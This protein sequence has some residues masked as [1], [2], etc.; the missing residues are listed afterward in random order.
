MFSFEVPVLGLQL[1]LF[2]I[3]FLR[4]SKGSKQHGTYTNKIFSNYEDSFIPV[5]LGIKA[6]GAS[7]PPSLSLSLSLSFSLSLSLSLSPLYCTF[8]REIQ[9]KDGSARF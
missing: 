2:I 6:E 8:H 7:L 4:A 1:R 3:Q 5:S 9:Q